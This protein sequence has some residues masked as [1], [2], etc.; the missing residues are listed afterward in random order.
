MPSKIVDAITKIGIG[1]ALTK[2][3]KSLKSENLEVLKVI[4][5]TPIKQIKLPNI[6]DVFSNAVERLD[7]VIA[8]QEP[9]KQDKQFKTSLEI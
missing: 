7:E 5:A 6:K 8:N 4:S 1:D 2:K 9:E 3:L